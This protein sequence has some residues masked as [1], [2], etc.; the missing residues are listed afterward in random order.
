MKVVFDLKEDAFDH[1]NSKMLQEFISKKDTDLLYNGEKVGE[2]IDRDSFW[3]SSH[4]YYSA[5]LKSHNDFKS[6]FRMVNK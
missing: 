5:S 1:I 2:I 3:I 6:K 4:C